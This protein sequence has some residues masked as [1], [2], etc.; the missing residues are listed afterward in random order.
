MK[1]F[2]SKVKYNLKVYF[3]QKIIKLVQKYFYRVKVSNY[4]FYSV[5]PSYYVKP[6]VSKDVQKAMEATGE[7]HIMSHSLI[8]PAFSNETSSEF[9]D[10]EVRFVIAKMF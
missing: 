2:S 4:R 9:Y 8:K 1:C 5:F 10:A 3:K 7:T 6:V